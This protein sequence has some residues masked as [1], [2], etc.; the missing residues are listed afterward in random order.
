M[1]DTLTTKIA[2][3][4]VLLSMAVEFAALGLA[5][6][7]GSG[8]ASMNAMNWGV[9]EQ[10]VIFQPSW[11]GILFSLAVLSPCLSMLAWPGMY[12]IL[13]PG[14]SSAFYGVIVSSLGMLFGVVAEAIRL[15]MVMTL[16]SAYVAAS[17]AARPAVLTLG[18]FLGHLFQILAQTSLIV[19]YAVGMPLIALAIVRGH[20]VPSWLGWLLLIPSALVGYVGGPLVSLGY[21]IGGPFIGVGLNIFFVWFVVIGVVL[22]RWDTSR[23]KVQDAA[24]TV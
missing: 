22:L 16:P 15:S 17:D 24:S 10:L 11:M 8:P 13:A 2:G 7:H 4:F 21:A 14:G 19:L 23:H 6:S 3:V 12:Y 18:A 1:K 5:F 20:N 9:G